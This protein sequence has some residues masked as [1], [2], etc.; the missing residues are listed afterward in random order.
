MSD[1]YIASGSRTP[2]G[3]FLGVLSDLSAV[4]LG[5]VTVKET[6]KRAA[7]APDSVD[8]LIFGC[9]LPAGLGQNPAR[10]VGIHSGIPPRVPAVTINK[11]CG[12]GMKAICFAAQTIRLGD[13]DVV[14]AGG[15]ESMSN[16]PFMLKNARKGV[17]LGNTELIDHM[18]YD[19]LWDVYGNFHMGET[20]ELVADKYGITREEM[21][22][23]AL[24]SHQRAVAAQRNGDFNDEIVPIQIKDKKGNIQTITKDEGPRES[25]SSNELAKLRPAFRKDGRVTPGN[26]STINDGAASLCLVSKTFADKK[27]VKP[28][29]RI[30]GYASAGVEPKWVMMAPVEAAKKMKEKHAIDIREFDL[31]EINEAFAGS[32][33]ALIRELKLD[34]NKVNVNGGAV[35]LGH[36]IGCSGARIVVTLMYAL[37]KRGLKTGYATLCLGGGNA[38]A[39]AIEL[40]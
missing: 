38:V 10:Q 17:R 23:F 25:T 5:V 20:C 37:K 27:G 33:V 34:H 22:N 31:I 35:A 19:G 28:L 30:L 16:A 32:T 2:I 1:V 12:S 29:A 4:N 39:L 26:A 9:V 21:D 6:L 15:M 11:V 14:V 18:V 36:P 40:C 3:K 8:E 24:T 7:V 13:A